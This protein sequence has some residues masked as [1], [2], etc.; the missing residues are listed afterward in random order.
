MHFEMAAWLL[1]AQGDFS[2][3]QAIN[4]E[5][6]HHYPSNFGLSSLD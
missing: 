6:N 3:W 1:V 4:T 5:I 2:I